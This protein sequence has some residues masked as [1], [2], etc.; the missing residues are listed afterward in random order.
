VARI[1]RVALALA[2]VL[3]AGCPTRR[4]APPPTP[5]LG[6]LYARPAGERT[7]P[8]GQVVWLRTLEPVVAESA[9]PDRS[10]SAL[11]VRDILDTAG[12]LMVPHGS[13]ARL[14]VMAEP[15]GR[16]T[17]AVHSVRVFGNTY[18]TRPAAAPAPSPE[19]GHPGMPLGTLVDGTAGAGLAAVPR[20]ELLVE[21][22]LI[23]VPD[24]TLLLYRLQQAALIE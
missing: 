7:I 4:V 11:V 8:A 13:Q 15:A 5:I 14:T 24:N 17:L 9:L 18:I 21:G 19:A 23:R 20:D 22:A 1:P 10:F 3:L 2:A 6:P 16:L 12:N